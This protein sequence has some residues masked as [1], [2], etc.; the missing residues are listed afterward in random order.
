MA[1]YAIGDV[2][3]CFATLRELLRRIRF[4]PGHDRL[5][6]V[7]DLVNRGPRSLEVLR[8]AIEQGD[9]LVT[10]LG[11][12]DLHLLARASGVGRPKRRDSL[13]PVLD[14]S[15]R[16][17]LLR[18]LV[19]R[20]LLHREDGHILVHAGVFPVWT[21]AQAEAL[22][23]ETEAALQGSGSYGLIASIDQK[24]DERWEDGLAPAD[25]ARVA[26]AG[27]AKIRTVTA[28]GR[29]CA[30]FSGAPGEAPKGCR[31]WFSV[32]GRETR[33]ETVIFG[34]WAALGLRIDDGVACLDTG[35]SYG[36]ELTAL[37]LD[38]RK[39]FRQPTVD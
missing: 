25:R 10:V 24:N 29:M 11:N 35:C 16:D 4:D 27:F 12:H 30:E 5:W 1:I 3:G 20:P 7:G 17:D 28:G 18:W 14:A 22:A 38:D 36:R 9:R 6:M 15:D 13:A 19:S 37:R 31:P 33:H 23:R 34:H 26:L 39:L 2:H 8:W 32:P 21:P